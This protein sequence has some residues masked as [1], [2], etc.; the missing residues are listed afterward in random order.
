M[1]TDKLAKFLHQTS[2]KYGVCVL[3]IWHTGWEI[4]HIINLNG[5]ELESQHHVPEGNKWACEVS[6]REPWLKW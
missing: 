3:G 4:F 1:V 5:A 2:P 6:I